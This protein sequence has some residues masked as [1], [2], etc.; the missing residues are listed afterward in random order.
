[1]MRARAQAY[2]RARSDPGLAVFFVD[3]PLAPDGR[4]ALATAGGQTIRAGTDKVLELIRDGHY[5]RESQGLQ[6]L[7]APQSLQQ[8]EAFVEDVQRVADAMDREVF[9]VAE[10][11]AT[12][13]YDDANRTF[14]TLGRGGQVIAWRAIRPEPPRGSLA[15]VHVWVDNGVVVVG[16]L[17]EPPAVTLHVHAD[18]ESGLVEPR[19]ADPAQRGGEL[20]AYVRD[21]GRRTDVVTIAAAGLA[22]LGQASAQQI[23]ELLTRLGLPP[24]PARPLRLVSDPAGPGTLPEVGARLAALASLRR[25]S[26]YLGT[27]VSYDWRARDL[28]AASWQRIEPEEAGGVP[29]PEEPLLARDELS[30]LLLPAAPP[31]GYGSGIDMGPGGAWPALSASGGPGRGG[32]QLLRDRREGGACPAF[33]RPQ[34]V[35]RAGHFRAPGE[36]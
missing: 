4:I 29:G 32:A 8:Y 6:F 17:V 15:G 16:D 18:T 1:M 31:Q 13:R 25:A 3:V 12:V 27:G 28:S 9:I 22:W 19:G 2:D 35:R 7:A 23:D 11:E 26:V 10:P 30:G 14:T 24:V 36:H 34:G 33:G 21:G 20:A 5:D